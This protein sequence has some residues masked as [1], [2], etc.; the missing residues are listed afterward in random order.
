M[1]NDVNILVNNL[2][3]ILLHKAFQLIMLTLYKLVLN[4]KA[5]SITFRI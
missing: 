5:H 4:N 3:D 1:I 2:I